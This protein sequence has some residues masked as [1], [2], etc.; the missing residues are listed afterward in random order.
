MVSEGGEADLGE[1]TAD[2]DYVMGDG[3]GQW[4]KAKKGGQLEKRERK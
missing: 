4:H 1:M 3:R 2:R